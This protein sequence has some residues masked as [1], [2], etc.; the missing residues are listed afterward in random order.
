MYPIRIH[1]CAPGARP[2]ATI[3]AAERLNLGRRREGDDRRGARVDGEA[4]VDLGLAQGVEAR[5][6]EGERLLSGALVGGERVGVLN[7]G[8]GLVPCDERG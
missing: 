4:T 2:W 6:N 5:L 1:F 3:D 8:H 7:V